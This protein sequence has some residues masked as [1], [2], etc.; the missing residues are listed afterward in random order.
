MP[1]ISVIIADLKDESKVKN[2]LDSILGQSYQNIEVIVFIDNPNTPYS[3]IIREYTNKE[4][5]LKMVEGVA[6]PDGWVKSNFIRDNLSQLAN[7][8]Y[9]VFVNADVRIGNELIANALSYMQFNG[10]SLLTVFPKQVAAGQWNRI[11]NG[12]KYWLLITMCPI[13]RIK[14]SSRISLSATANQF[15][16]FESTSYKTNRWHEKYKSF[17][18]VD[19][20]IGRFLKN[21][22][23]KMASLLGGDEITILTS[24]ND[25]ENTSSFIFNFFGRN[26]NRLIVYAIAS[27]LG[28]V[29]SV[30]LLPFP[31]VFLYLFSL[32]FARMQFAM[33]YGIS[34]FV[35]L[36]LLPIH[37]FVFLY[38]VFQLLKKRSGK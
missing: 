12:V 38:V 19:F 9:L 26:S 15:M 22:N 2:L 5:R 21:G 34:P 27:T 28:L 30:F 24:N 23:L 16:M 37:H 7:G 1:L 10:L 36:L 18:D 6:V 32:F 25:F 29:L 4:K 11:L 14:N 33:I 17:K 35:T 13:K 20:V 31:L 8:Q 3:P